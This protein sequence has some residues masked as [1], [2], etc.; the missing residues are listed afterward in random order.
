MLFFTLRLQGIDLA[1]RVLIEPGD[2][3]IVEAPSYFLAL[4]SFKAAGARVIEIPMDEN[5]MKV[6][7]LEKYVQRYHPK[8][9]YTIPE[10]QNPS[11]ICMSLENRKKL[12][13]IAYKY[14][15]III[16]D[17]A[18]R[19]L[20]YDDESINSISALDDNGYVIYLSTFSKRVCPGLR[21]GYLV[22]DKQ[23]VEKCS[24]VRQTIDVHPSTIFQWLVEEY[25]SSG[26]LDKHTKVICEE[27]REKREEMQASLLK[28]A[29]KDLKWDKP[30]GGYYFWCTLPRGIKS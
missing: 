28:Y 3:V 16:E 26:E 4:Q 19:E 29:P 2:I 17:N 18:Y 10:Y 14:E 15:I 13:E 12:L 5:G 6:A 1:A 23:I 20:G 27:Y 24:M 22:A 11:S 9:I 25:I 21:L 8:C 30:K 7:S